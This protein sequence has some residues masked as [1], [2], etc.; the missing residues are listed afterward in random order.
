[1]SNSHSRGLNEAG[2]LG[3]GGGGL[4][5][6]K[7]GVVGRTSEGYLRLFSLKRSTAGD[8]ALPFKVLS[9]KKN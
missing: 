9:R 1:M 3:G 4:P 2:I 5:N 8:L 6:K 7:D